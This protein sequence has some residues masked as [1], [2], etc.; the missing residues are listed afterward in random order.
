MGWIGRSD[1]LDL[2]I[3]WIAGLVGSVGSAPCS[4]GC[5]GSHLVQAVPVRVGRRGM[6]LKRL[7]CR[8]AGQLVVRLWMNRSP[9][10]TPVQ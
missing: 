5:V 8:P 10:P 4:G 7:V 1:R 9:A 6:A 3:G 2:W